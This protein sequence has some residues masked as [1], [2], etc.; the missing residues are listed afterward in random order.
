MLRSAFLAI[1]RRGA[2]AGRPCD[3]SRQ[4]CTVKQ[5]CLTG[6]DGKNSRILSGDEDGKNS[7]IVSGDEDGKN[8]RIASGDEYAGVITGEGRSAGGSF[9]YE[10]SAK[11]GAKVFIK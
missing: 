11:R 3:I 8:S 6:V 2:A 7:R 10:L 4:S 5:D 1:G 9:C